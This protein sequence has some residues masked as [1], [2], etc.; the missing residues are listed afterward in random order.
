MLPYNAA[1]IYCHSLWSTN[2]IYL[3]TFWLTSEHLVILSLPQN[4]FRP[5]S[6]HSQ[7]LFNAATFYLCTVGC[8]FIMI[9][10][11]DSCLFCPSHWLSLYVR[12][13]DKWLK[14]DVSGASEIS[15]WTRLSAGRMD[16]LA[17]SP[18]TG[19]AFSLQPSRVHRLGGMIGCSVKGS[20]FAF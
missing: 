2:A 14:C 3:H 15:F 12:E 16:A 8:S 5:W 1:L 13:S 19:L 18:W 7:C 11:T 4:F 20:K 9:W 17:V 6:L 10:E